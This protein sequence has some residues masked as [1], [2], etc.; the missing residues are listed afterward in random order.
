MTVNKQIINASELA[1]NVIK[2]YEL[3]AGELITGVEFHNSENGRT[4]HRINLNGSLEVKLWMQHER[5]TPSLFSIYITIYDGKWLLRTYGYLDEINVEYKSETTEQ[6]YTFMQLKEWI[7]EF[8]D[9]VYQ[10]KAAEV[11]GIVVIP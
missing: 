10:L 2:T 11:H 1:R 7:N 6:Q 3:S 5:M 9:T 8:V 4:K